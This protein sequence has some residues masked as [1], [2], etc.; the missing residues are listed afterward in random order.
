MMKTI[1]DSKK[2]AWLDPSRSRILN[3]L[4]RISIY[5]QFCAGATEDEVRR[6]VSEMK[7]MGFTG[8]ILGYA[9][10]AVV[11]P[12][13]GKG[14]TMAKVEDR[15]STSLKPGCELTHEHIVLSQD[16]MVDAWKEGNLRTLR[17]I[18]EGDYLAIK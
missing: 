15:S 3:Y 8:V 2:S 5:G 9:R 4:L 14:K 11:I 17:M 6:T 18:G 12:Q 16:A 1:A 10:D 7:A 13:K